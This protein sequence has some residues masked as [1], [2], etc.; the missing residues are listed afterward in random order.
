MKR[1]EI[2]LET[3]EK[4]LV[5]RM[6]RKL[7]HEEQLYLDRYLVKTRLSLDEILEVFVKSE[8]K[9]ISEVFHT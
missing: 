8:S 6:G 1:G 9:A 7:N 5:R 2:S 4:E 3:F